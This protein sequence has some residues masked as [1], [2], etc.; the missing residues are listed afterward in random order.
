M[1]IDELRRLVY[2]WNADTVLDE[3]EQRR[4]EEVEIWVSPRDYE[5]VRQVVCS[6]NPLME[7]NVIANSRVWDGQMFLFDRGSQ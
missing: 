5:M 4:R 3:V 7:S 1:T 2:E 6:I